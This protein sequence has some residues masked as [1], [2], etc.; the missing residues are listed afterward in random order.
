MCI[1]CPVQWWH[2][3]NFRGDSGHRNARPPRQ[4]CG[5]INRGRSMSVC[6]SLSPHGGPER[7][8][9]GDFCRMPRAT[10]LGHD[11]GS[12]GTCTRWEEPVGEVG[13][14][15]G[16]AQGKGPRQSAVPRRITWAPAK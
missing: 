7:G 13:E 3:V 8:I 16:G 6:V 11:V 12:K 1:K 4:A 10:G 2:S 14:P 9:P 5:S 15:G